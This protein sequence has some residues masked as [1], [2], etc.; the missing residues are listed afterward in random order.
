MSQINMVCN[1]EE[2]FDDCC[3]TTVSERALLIKY[4]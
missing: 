3:I 1:R 4:F 2:R